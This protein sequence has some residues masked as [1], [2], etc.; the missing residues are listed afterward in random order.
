MLPDLLCQVVRV[1]FLR[2]LESAADRL[3]HYAAERGLR[4]LSPADRLLLGAAAGLGHALAAAGA[5][6]VGLLPYS[7]GPGTVYTPK[8][9]RVSLFMAAAWQ[10]LAWTLLHGGSMVVAIAGRRSHKPTQ[11]YAP[12]VYHAACAAAACLSLADG[13]CVAAL[14]LQVCIGALA[15]AHAMLV[16]ARAAQSGARF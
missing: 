8:C 3:D 5:Y 1:F 4:M 6:F 13:G 9:A 10:C 14:P 16:A 15:A 7:A 2:Y 12:P 11:L